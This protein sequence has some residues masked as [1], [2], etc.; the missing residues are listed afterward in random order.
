MN[1]TMQSM[2]THDLLTTKEKI[3]GKEGEVDPMDPTVGMTTFET[4]PDEEELFSQ[5]QYPRR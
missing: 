5:R 3:A 2:A 1:S 4:L